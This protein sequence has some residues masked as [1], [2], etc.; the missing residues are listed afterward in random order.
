MTTKP[1][2]ARTNNA[3]AEREQAAN[4]EQSENIDR[5]TVPAGQTPKK[6]KRQTDPILLATS[7]LDQLLG[8]VP[9]DRRQWVLN[10]LNLKYGQKPTPAA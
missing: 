1:H 8:Q 7:R 5:Q 3:E 9:E 2:A 10:W 4:N 6:A